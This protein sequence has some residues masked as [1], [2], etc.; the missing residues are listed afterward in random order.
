MKTQR[1]GGLS[2]RLV[3]LCMLHLYTLL[4][5]LG[6]IWRSGLGA[7]MTVSVIAIALALPSVFLLTIENLEGATRS[8]RSLGEITVFARDALN[9]TALA[10]LATELESIDSVQSVRAMTA[11]QALSEFSELSGFSD[12]LDALQDNPLP[13][14]VIVSPQPASFEAAKMHQLIEQ[15]EQHGDVDFAQYDLD[16]MLRL[17]AIVRVV[18]RGIEVVGVLFALAVLLVVG[19]TIRLDILN[20]REEIMVSKLIGATDAFV[21][22]PFLYTGFWY[23][24]LGGALAWALLLIAF[25]LLSGPVAELASSYGE[26]FELAGA[27]LMY[28]VQLI[29]VSA[30]LGWL[31]SGLAVRRHLREIEPT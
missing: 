10:A 9:E 18:G 8:G 24:L 15:I 6:R 16:W 19:N 20:R 5:S 4:A 12:A 14:V 27:G 23:G 1:S 2:K 21:R 25:V 3:G 30:L 26:S 29:L 22:R 31:G 13:A 28:G 17:A 11:D 7:L